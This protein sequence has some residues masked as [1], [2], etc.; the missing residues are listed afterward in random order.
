[1]S[2]IVAALLL[3]GTASASS[4]MPTGD[5]TVV[6]S[7]VMR[8]SDVRE[9]YGRLRDSSA[10]DFGRGALPSACNPI[11]SGVSVIGKASPQTYQSELDFAGNHMWQN[12][13]F[14]YQSVEAA[15]ASFYQ[16][17]HR[18]LARCQGEA[19]DPYGDDEADVPNVNANAARRL[20]ADRMW[21]RFTAASSHILL[22][23]A[24]APPGYRDN[25]GFTVFTLVD[26][27]IVQVQLYSAKALSE[28]NRADVVNVARLVA[29]RYGAAT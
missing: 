25:F 10:N 16:L 3:M 28:R 29:L 5:A 19:F 6:P 14:T 20:P 4:A 2:A 22:D 11:T 26:N 18:A 15:R 21:P 13:V 27:A 9:D 23:P 24:K 8:Q 12:S 7:Y 1:V 17:R